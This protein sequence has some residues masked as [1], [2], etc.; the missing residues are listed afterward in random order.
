MKDDIC[1]SVIV[2]VYNTK[3][4]LQKLLDSLLLQTLDN[5]ELIFVDD[6]SKDGSFEFLKDKQ[7]TEK[8]ISVYRNKCNLGGGGTRNAG[9]GFATGKYVIFIDSDDFVSVN[10]LKDMYESGIKNDADVVIGYEGVFIDDQKKIYVPDRAGKN[11][12]LLRTYPVVN[13]PMNNLNILELITNCAFDKMIRR[14][15]LSEY[16]IEFSGYPYTN[17]M[18]LSFSCILH[19]KCV[20]YV[21]EV[22]YYTRKERSGNSNNAR[23]HGK[24]YIVLIL[25]EI[26]NIISING[27]TPSMNEEFWQFAKHRIYQAA[28]NLTD[29]NRKILKEEADSFLSENGREFNTDYILDPQKPYSENLFCAQ[30]NEWKNLKKISISTK[31]TVMVNNLFA[32]YLHNKGKLMDYYVNTELFSA[33]TIVHILHSMVKNKIK[34]KCGVFTRQSGILDE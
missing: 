18:L 29:E 1:V 28:Y 24:S 10:M 23:S 25:R 34:N 9:L 7:Q 14:S 19:A 3:K 12:A 26:L 17:D 2:P 20:V 4:Y 15:L 33:G 27:T 32:R 21:D 5:I 16:N 13:Y 30:K 11:R 22:V 31:G 8:R 6:C